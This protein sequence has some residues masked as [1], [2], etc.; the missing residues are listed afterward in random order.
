MLNF[1]QNALNFWIATPISS[2]RNDEFIGVAFGNTHPQPPPQ[3]RGLFYTFSKRDF[4]DFRL[5]YKRHK[6][7]RLRRLKM[8]KLCDKF[9]TFSI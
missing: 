2:A 4:V 5:F 7:A 6:M 1:R 9:S 3:G 8:T